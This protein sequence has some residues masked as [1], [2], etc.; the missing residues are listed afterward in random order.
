MDEMNEAKTFSA[1]NY[2]S[3]KQKQMNMTSDSGT[4]VQLPT[5]NKKS[6]FLY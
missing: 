6:G 2:I 4:T 3:V 5:K 1:I